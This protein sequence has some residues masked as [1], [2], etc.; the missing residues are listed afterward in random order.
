[1][2]KAKKG[3]LPEQREESFDY[4]QGDISAVPL[5]CSLIENSL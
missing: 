1:M 3:E 2:N 5:S 4:A